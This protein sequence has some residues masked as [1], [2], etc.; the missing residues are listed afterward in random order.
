MRML[1]S[2]N[3]AR[4][5]AVAFGSFAPLTLLPHTLLPCGSTPTLLVPLA[6]VRGVYSE[7][8]EPDADD[9]LSN[10]DRMEVDGV[11]LRMPCVDMAGSE[12]R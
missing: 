2:L 10:G 9:E 11:K 8:G 7:R 4:M 6:G 3:A 12:A 1:P 5:L